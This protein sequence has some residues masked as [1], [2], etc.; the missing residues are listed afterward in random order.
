VRAGQVVACFETKFAYKHFP[1]KIILVTA[2][3]FENGFPVKQLCFE[4]D[5]KNSSA[6][7]GIQRYAIQ[8]NTI[9]L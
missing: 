2:A 9:C 3:C 1:L 4:N 5:L 6:I 8:I 7:R